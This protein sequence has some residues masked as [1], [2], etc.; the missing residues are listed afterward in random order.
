M[1]INDLAPQ[2]TRNCTTPQSFACRYRFVVITAPLTLVIYQPKVQL[3]LEV[4][5][6][7]P[8]VPVP[9]MIDKMVRGN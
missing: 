1:P 8:G 6:E 5:V 4:V 3:G 7:G 2:K 9:A